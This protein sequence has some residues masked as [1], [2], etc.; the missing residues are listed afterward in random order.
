[1]E[2]NGQLQVNKPGIDFDRRRILEK[3]EREERQNAIKKSVK[4]LLKV[5]LGKSNV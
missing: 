2:F 3:R 1:M 4:K 5:I